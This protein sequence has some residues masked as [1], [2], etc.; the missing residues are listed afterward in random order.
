MDYKESAERLMYYMVL[1]EERGSII[2]KRISELAHGELAVLRFLSEK[3][4]GVNAGELS[5]RFA[6]NTSR[7]AAILNSLEKKG[8]IDRMT[9]ER[10]KRMVRIFIRP[11]GIEYEKEKC[12]QFIEHGAAMLE[13]LGEEDAARYIDIMER[14]AKIHNDTT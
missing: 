3:A 2:Q 8:F 13:R 12:S 6:I 9:D 4:D 1:N 11:Q 10:D 7:V 5:K 14:L